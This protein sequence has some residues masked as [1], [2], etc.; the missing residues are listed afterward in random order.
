MN[1]ANINIRIILTKEMKDLEYTQ[2][3]IINI[4]SNQTVI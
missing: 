1:E 2:R 3:R 4:K